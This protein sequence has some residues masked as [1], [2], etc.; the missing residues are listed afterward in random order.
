MEE[1][2]LAKYEG[3]IPTKGTPGQYI[4]KC[5]D[6]DINEPIM[7]DTVFN[8]VFMEYADQIIIDDFS[9][10]EDTASMMDENWVAIGYKN[11]QW[12]E[13]TNAAVSLS[14]KSD[15]GDK[16]L[17][18][19]AWANTNDYKFAKK[20][21]ANAFAKSA[22]ALQFKLAVPTYMTVKVLLHATVKIGGSEQQPYFSYT[23]KNRLSNEYVDYTIPLNDD[24]WALWNEE[25]KSIST[26]A[27][28][29]GVQEDALLNYLT[30]I[31]FYFKGN[32]G[33][34][35]K[36]VAYLD[37][38]RFVTLNNPK[39]ETHEKITVPSVLTGTTKSGNTLRV[40][41]GD[42]ND[43]VAS[44]I[45][46]QT[47]VSVN[48]KTTVSGN[49]FVFTSNDNG[50]TLTYKANI[51]DG[52]TTVKYVEATGSLAAEAEEMDL[53]AVQKV[54]D[55]EQYKE[56][57]K[58]FYK[59]GPIEE[60][61]GC[62][63]DFYSEYYS[64]S[65]ADN[66]PWGGL[67]W[68]LMGDNG[69]QLKLKQDNT[70]HSGTNYLCMK[71][72][73]SYGMRYMQ[74]GLFDGS[75]ERHSFRGNYMG[76]WAKTNGVVKKF[77]AYMYYQNAPTNA[78]RDERV[79]KAIFTE[80]G[81]V[82]EWKHYELELNP[83][84]TYYGYMFFIDANWASDSYLYIDDV[85]VYGA[86][87]Y[88]TYVEP[89]P[90]QPFA[91]TPGLTYNAKI[92]DL[93]QAFLDV[94]A[95]NKV[96]FRAPG[97]D[98]V[99][100]GSY[101]INEET[102]DITFTLDGGITYVLTG[103]KENDQLKFKSING[104]GI[105]ANALNGLDFNLLMY[106]DNAESYADAG[107]MY[108]QGNTNEKAISGAR[109][110][111][112]CDYY[113]GSGTSPIGGSGWN[114]MGGNGDQLTLDTENHYEGKQSLKMKKSTAGGM[115]YIQWDLF[116]GTAKAK[117]GV[118]KFTVY[119]KN[120]ASDNTQLKIYVFTEQ[121]ITST[122]HTTARVSKD[123]TLTANQDWT[124]Y[125][126]E[127]DPSKTYYG[128]GIFL[129][130]ASAVGWINVDNA[131]FYGPNNDASLNFYAKKDMV[132]SGNIT[133]GPASLKFG[134]AGKATFT[135]AALNATDVAATYKMA[136]NGNNQEITISFGDNVI[137]G[138]YAVDVLG[139]VTLTIVSATGSAAAYINAGATLTN[140]VN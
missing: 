106:G 40:N 76:F 87:P 135:C 113:T 27:S 9:K 73:A 1:G 107:Q 69:D 95:A 4:F 102:N 129:N 42:N 39:F 46:L 115:R 37:S 47:P 63:G 127:L 60:R 66:S 10:Y 140:T 130:Q 62:R 67:K 126:V 32:D 25:G 117:T 105:I 72:S 20:F 91:L 13:E 108:Y 17:R 132:L 34:G 43:T 61:S 8:A 123:V 33:N 114:L 28:W 109:G 111:Y 84:K 90:E 82:G 11:N 119:L 92:K 18:F 65:D 86:S 41:I 3:D 97:L 96:T 31:E 94:K 26:C 125:T 99:V 23:L 49:S 51:T 83:T 14:Y 124:A 74:W 2:E 30:R 136:M 78:T 89:E 35:G 81:A 36:F 98:M 52:G 93:Y 101:A 138:T 44:I 121:Q 103:S 55:F 50:Q 122:N 24:G 139:N 7:Q 137:V 57:G 85:E 133:A 70:A 77:T 100:D 15:E 16:A 54:D 38:A 104:S 29:M 118:D 19:D 56:D 79:S 48:G 134:D 21:K 71:N 45:D 128:Y 6:P 116:K 58:A 12:T 131:M 59:D 5:W 112:Y 22:N 120:Q 68:S 64:N 75:S 88:A 53:V 110:A 80:T